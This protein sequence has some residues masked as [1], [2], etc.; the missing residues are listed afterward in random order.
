MARC[1]VTQLTGRQRGA[2]LVVGLVLLMVLTVLAIS[3][4]RT[5]TLEL[6]MAGNAQFRENAFQLAE[7]GVE[8]VMRG[9]ATGTIDLDAVADCP[10]KPAPPRPWNDAELA[11][12]GDVAVPVLRGRYQTRLCLDGT[13]TDM[14]GSS[15]G[16]FRQLHYRVEAR[17][18]TDQRNAE[19]IHAQGFYRQVEE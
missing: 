14:P 13:T 1:T 2:A 12:S 10:P 8:A 15:I 16:P 17:G 7:S 18:R 5:A 11:W 19:A 3:V 4:M 6:T 9:A